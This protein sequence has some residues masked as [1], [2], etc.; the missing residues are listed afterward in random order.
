[1][2]NAPNPPVCE[3]EKK[4]FAGTT[5]PAAITTAIKTKLAAEHLGSLAKIHVDT[6]A[7]GIVTLRGTAKSQEDIDKAVASASKTKGVRSVNNELTIKK[8]D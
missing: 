6:D 7:N 5:V 2:K 4:P 1:M 3:K 8:D